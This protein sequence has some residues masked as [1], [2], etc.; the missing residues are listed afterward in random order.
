MHISQKWWSSPYLVLCKLES[1]QNTLGSNVHSS[2]VCTIF[3]GLEDIDTNREER[4]T[5]P[6]Q[7]GE[8]VREGL[9]MRKC[10]WGCGVGWG[11][12]RSITVT[13]SQLQMSEIWKVGGC[14]VKSIFH[15][16][17]QIIEFLWPKHYTMGF[18]NTI[19]G[20]HKVV[21]SLSNIEI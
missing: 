8:C 3:L 12:L 14:I 18:C 15:E 17:V 9:P 11:C 10:Q 21:F 13:W 7:L 2:R 1:S 4:S 6:W 16:A 20:T 5:V 19:N